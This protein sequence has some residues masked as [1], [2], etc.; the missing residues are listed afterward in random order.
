VAD[1][2]AV[3]ETWY[4]WLEQA[5]PIHIRPE[6]LD[7][8]ARALQLDENARRHMRFLAGIPVVEPDPDR[9]SALPELAALVDDLMPHPANLTTTALD[10][11]AC[12]RALVTLYL[13]P[14][15]LPVQHR[16][17]LWI[18]FMASGN[19]RFPDW[20]K[21]A[22]QTIARFRFERGRYPADPRFEELIT[23]LSQKS[24]KFVELWQRGGVQPTTGSD[25]VV[26]HPRFGEMR[27]VKLN[28]RPVERDDHLLTVHRAAD[29]QTKS[30]LEDMLAST[31]E[32]AFV[33]SSPEAAS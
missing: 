2:A 32:Q 3:S 31:N 4:T 27:F 22:L 14:R 28:L 6:S 12:N 33:R 29:A 16:N 8:V 13:N 9:P 20:E 23:E 21:S 24:P 7:G 30:I 18:A 1:L 15:D 19:A 10:I 25:F 17:S 26:V 11:V 5:R